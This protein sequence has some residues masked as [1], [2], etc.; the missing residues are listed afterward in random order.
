M[1]DIVLG[2]LKAQEGSLLVDDVE[3]DDSKRRKWQANLGYVP[4]T[5][6]LID[7][8]IKRNI[9]FGVPDNE[10]DIEAVKRAAVI[11]NL[12]DFIE[13]EL[14][15]GFDSMVGERGVRL[16]GGQRQR[17]GIARAVYHNPSVLIMDEATSALDG[18]TENA[19]MD[20]INNLSHKKTIIIV[21]HRLTTVKACD[22]IFIM[23]KGEIIDR[24]TYDDLLI[25]NE[26][27]RIMAV[28]SK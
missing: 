11:A 10:I 21:A 25:R 6:Y 16:S 3:I 20:A 27:F 5:I 15:E 2:L 19:I 18:L 8:S 9:A 28:G 17:I 12:D 24:G 13:N 1:I 4:Q 26:S 23:D 7:D 14:E 22:E